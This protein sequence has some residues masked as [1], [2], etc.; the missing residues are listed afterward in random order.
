MPVSDSSC[1]SSPLRLLCSLCFRSAPVE[2]TRGHDKPA[3][4]VHCPG[5]GT[6]VH[7][8][9]TARLGFFSGKYGICQHCGQHATVTSTGKMR[10]HKAAE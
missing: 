8:R 9:E 10:K 3:D 6:W 2:W 4:D 7:P 5:S 1:S